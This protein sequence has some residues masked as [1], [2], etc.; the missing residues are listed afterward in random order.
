M[1]KNY[2][3]GRFKPKFPDKYNGDAGN[4]IYRSSWELRVFDY[5]DR[6]SSIVWWSSEELIIPYR[7]PIDGKVHRYFPDVVLKTTKNKIHVCE[8]KPFNQIIPPK[9]RKRTTKK[10]LTEIETY[11]KNKAKW[12]AAKTYCKKKGWQFQLITEKTLG[13]EFKP[14]KRAK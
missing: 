5:L 6:H 7:S 1:S 8:I 12:D 4:I 13:I 11:G 10:Y 9:P 14:F 3:Q 2:Y